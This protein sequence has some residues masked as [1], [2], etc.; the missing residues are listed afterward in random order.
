MIH[1]EWPPFSI[2][3][4]PRG[5]IEWP[6][7]SHGIIHVEWWNHHIFPMVYMIHVKWLAFPM[8][9]DPLGMMESPP[10]SHCIYDPREVIIFSHSIWS[11]WNLYEIKLLVV[12]YFV[13]FLSSPGTYSD[14][15]R[16]C[17]ESFFVIS[18]VVGTVICILQ[19]WRSKITERFT[20]ITWNGS[21]NRLV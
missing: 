3:C 7:F 11:T 17:P 18:S 6:P 16:A 19:Q 21:F 9:Y 8:V 12:D 20:I 5:M 2:V 1:V 15:V 13:V 14:A 4:D 10:F